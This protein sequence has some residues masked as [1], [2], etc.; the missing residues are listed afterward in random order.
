MISERTALGAHLG[1][2]FIRSLRGAMS[3]MYM[4]AGTTTG[5]PLILGHSQVHLKYT[6]LTFI[7]V[8]RTRCHL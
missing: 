4:A 8:T 2:C 3:D 6:S 7:L 5:Y 1:I